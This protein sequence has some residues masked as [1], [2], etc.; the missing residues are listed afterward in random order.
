MVGYPPGSPLGLLAVPSFLGILL[1]NAILLRNVH[2]T[3]PPSP[4]V[5][6]GSPQY[7]DVPWVKCPWVTLVELTGGGPRKG[8]AQGSGRT[9]RKGLAQGRARPLRKD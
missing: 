4:A 8:L 3:T 9:P 1:S 7:H 2:I 6:W 5:P